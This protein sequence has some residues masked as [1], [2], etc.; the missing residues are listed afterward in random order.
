[1]A[2]SKHD[3][4]RVELLGSILKVL[5]HINRQPNELQ[6]HDKYRERAEM[7]AALTGRR[8]PSEPLPSP[9]LR[10]WWRL[11][12]RPSATL[13]DTAKPAPSGSDVH[14]VK[15]I[16]SY[17]RQ[18]LDIMIP[19][20]PEGWVNLTVEETLPIAN[21]LKE[22]YAKVGYSL[23]YVL[24]VNPARFY[25][26]GYEEKTGV[27]AVPLNEPTGPEGSFYHDGKTVRW[28]LKHNQERL[29]KI[30]ESYAYDATERCIEAL[31]G[32]V[33][34]L[35]PDGTRYLTKAEFNAMAFQVLAWRNELRL[36]YDAAV[37]KHK[38]DAV[39]PPKITMSGL[40]RAL[41][42]LAVEERGTEAG[43]VFEGI[44]TGT[45][46]P[47]TKF[48]SGA[49]I[50]IGQFK[51]DPA[52][53]PI[54]WDEA[55]KFKPPHGSPIEYKTE[56]GDIPFYRSRFW[57]DIDTGDAKFN[58]A[59][60]VVGSHVGEG[61]QQVI[62]KIEI[63]TV[64][65]EPVPGRVSSITFHGLPDA[66]D[67]VKPRDDGQVEIRVGEGGEQAVDAA[68]IHSIKVNEPSEPF[69]IHNIAKPEQAD[70]DTSWHLGDL[71]ESQTHVKKNPK[72]TLVIVDDLEHDEPLTDSQPG[73]IL[74]AVEPID[75]FAGLRYAHEGIARK[76]GGV[77]ECRSCRIAHPCPTA[78]LIIAYDELLEEKKHANGEE[79]DP[80]R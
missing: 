61:G 45:G 44:L 41:T 54:N 13:T 68:L 16:G 69:I 27:Y 2:K 72:T 58:V 22:C 6:A 35:T 79:V 80:L 28:A 59:G 49:K 74:P 73:S 66:A 19:K 56:F 30:C 63:H 48:S 46:D 38:A 51:V 11:E 47:F 20:S 25:Q 21:R 52:V 39:M 64:S 9:N 75:P 23:N 62:D 29:V 76:E 55:Q 7:Y 17:I 70:D 57:R 3:K 71:D 1:M 53:P 10:S 50:D 4:Y 43:A 31:G 12:A 33:P 67:R 24:D 5:D 8:A 32:L 77:L 34:L 15:P 36:M 14:P 18:I 37:A 42:E 60:A 26:V 40:D 78:K 65:P